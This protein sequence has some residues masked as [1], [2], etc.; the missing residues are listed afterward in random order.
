MLHW[1]G[2]SQWLAF[3]WIPYSKSKKRQFKLTPGSLQVQWDV[4]GMSHLCNIVVEEGLHKKYL[5]L[6]WWKK[7]ANVIE[8]A[9]ECVIDRFSINEMKD[10]TLGMSKQPAQ[11]WTPTMPNMKK[12]KKQR[13]STLPSMGRVSK[14][15]ITK[16]LMPFGRRKWLFWCLESASKWT[17][18]EYG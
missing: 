16:I 18:L 14:S 5:N 10:E 7:P 2:I 6:F 13:R 17:H 12:T 11:S 1:G 3:Q 9:I 4:V 15:S 8:Q